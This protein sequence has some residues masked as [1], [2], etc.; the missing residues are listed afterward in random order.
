[1]IRLLINFLKLK[2][3]KYSCDQGILYVDSWPPV[4]R[5]IISFLKP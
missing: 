5:W 3:E 1:M 2:S 4:L